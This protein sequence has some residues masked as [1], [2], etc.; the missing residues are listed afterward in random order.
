MS[1]SLDEELAQAVDETGSAESDAPAVAS[2]KD[3]EPRARSDKGMSTGAS[4]GLL[5]VLLCMAGGIVAVVLMG[6]KDAAVYAMPTDQ[7]VAR[8]KELQGRKV[9]VDGELVPGTLQ[10]RDAPCEYRF[11]MQSK[12]QKLDVRYPQ[13]VIPDTFRDR[14]EGGVQV[15]VEGALDKAGSFDASTV[16]AK[17]SSKYDPKTHEIIQP[18]GTRVK[19]SPSASLDSELVQ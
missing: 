19:A 8:A 9:R 2:S 17:C 3:P 15:T 1:K 14:P 4:I 10:K 16:M 12:G 13:C 18:D 7:L 6:F 11:T 5:A